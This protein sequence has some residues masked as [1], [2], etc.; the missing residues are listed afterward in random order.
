MAQDGH[1]VAVG[2]VEQLGQPVLDL[3]IVVG[4][5]QG[6]PGGGLERA[7]AWFVETA[8]QLFQIDRRHKFFSIFGSRLWSRRRRQGDDPAT[9]TGSLFMGGALSRNNCTKPRRRPR[10][11]ETAPGAVPNLLA[12]DAGID[13]QPPPR[14][15]R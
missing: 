10:R 7:A 6:Q 12:G 13:R 5:R 1:D 9:R 8:D 11:P 15:S 3:D 2:N 4:A 14:R